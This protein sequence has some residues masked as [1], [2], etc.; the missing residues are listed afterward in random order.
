MLGTNFGLCLY[1][2]LVISHHISK[3]MQTVEVMKFHRVG[4]TQKSHGAQRV[5]IS[6]RWCYL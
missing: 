1:Y 5:N 2:P 4:D 6:A 3:N